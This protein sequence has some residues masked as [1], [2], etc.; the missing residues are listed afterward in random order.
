MVIAMLLSLLLAQATTAPK[1]A[2]PQPAAPPKT[3][4]APQQPTTPPKTAPAPPR[5]TTAAPT[6]GDR[7]LQAWRSFATDGKGTPFEDVSVELSGGRQP[8]RAEKR[9]PAGQIN[10]PGLR[11]GTYRLRFSGASVTAF[12]R[13][14]TL[15]AGEIAKLRSRSPRRSRPKL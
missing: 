5:T 7:R 10:F 12:E 4:P 8:R 13:E 2:P 15:K 9:M 11:A 6:R 14:I 1:P 3:A